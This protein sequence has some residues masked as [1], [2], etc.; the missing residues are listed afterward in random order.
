[1]WRDGKG[2]K[3]EGWGGGGV[4]TEEEGRERGAGVASY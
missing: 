3:V 4:D 2:R 1:M